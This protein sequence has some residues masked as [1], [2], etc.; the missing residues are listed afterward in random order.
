MIDVA[1]AV[2]DDSATDGHGGGHYEGWDM[3][4]P[5]PAG[6]AARLQIA[7]FLIRL[8]ERAGLS[9]AEAAAKAGISKPTV[10]RYENWLTQAKLTVPTVT[11]LARAY[12]ATQQEIDVLVELTRR[13]ADGWMPD[14]HTVPEW[15]DALVSIEAAAQYEYAFSAR[16]VPGLLQ[17]RGYALATHEA[18][19]ARADPE[20]IARR[21]EGRMQR[22]N[23]LER[24]DLHLWVIID[25]AVLRRVVGSRQ[26]MAEQIEHLEEMT[27]RP[28]IALQVL[29]DSAGPS[30]VGAGGNF[31]ILG[32]DGDDG[33]PLSA[34]AV[35]YL[36]TH[37]RGAYLDGPEDV[38]AYRLMYQRLTAH[39]AD[40]ATTLDLLAAARQEY[41]G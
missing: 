3:S 5:G 29:P 23:A 25:E 2:R 30:A 41:T 40:T 11:A 4:G 31:V 33:Q 7:R 38:A 12:Q 1:G 18:V 8:R 17:T 13:Q 9:Q 6:P 15:M 16:L 36:E 35:V 28:N 14:P 27:R 34:M 22:Q 32:R 26:V 39:A 37:R 19:D 21:V 24:P 10:S 20:E